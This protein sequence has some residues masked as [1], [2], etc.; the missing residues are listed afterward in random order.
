MTFSLIKSL[1]SFFEKDK[2]ELDIEKLKMKYDE[3]RLFAGNPA[4][5]AAVCK[6]GKWGYIDDTGELVIPLKY[7]K[8]YDF[9]DNFATVYLD[10]PIRKDGPIRKQGIIIDKWGAWFTA[11]EQNMQGGLLKSEGSYEFYTYNK[12]FEEETWVHYKEGKFVNYSGYI[13]NNPFYPKEFYHK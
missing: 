7:D 6:N 12:V 11:P 5:R 2:K 10:Y 13:Y 8:V 3:I 1:S 9:I 4:N